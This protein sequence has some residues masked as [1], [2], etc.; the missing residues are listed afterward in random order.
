MVKE[1]SVS[2]LISESESLHT[3]YQPDCEYAD[4]I[5]I[6]RNVGTAELS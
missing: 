1:M 3:D 2:L 5:L 6:E 4:G